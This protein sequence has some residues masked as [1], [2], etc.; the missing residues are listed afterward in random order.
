MIGFSTAIP[1]PIEK[2][3]DLEN[4]VAGSFNDG[5]NSTDRLIQQEEG[6]AE[7]VDQDGGIAARVGR[8]LRRRRRR[9]Q[10]QSH[11]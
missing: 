4:R 6:P 8:P 9:M 11:E 5:G 10:R 3:L 7:G 2:S 1:P